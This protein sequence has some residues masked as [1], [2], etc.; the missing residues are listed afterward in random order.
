MRAR[1]VSTLRDL[2]WQMGHVDIEVVRLDKHPNLKTFLPHF[3]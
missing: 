2:D 3:Q 1:E